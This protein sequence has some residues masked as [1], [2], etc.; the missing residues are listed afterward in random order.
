MQC[1]FL[2]HCP[3]GTH[4]VNS[5]CIVYFNTL[6]RHGLLLLCFSNCFPGCLF[7]YIFQFILSFLFT[8]PEFHFYLS[9]FYTFPAKDFSVYVTQICNL[10]ITLRCKLTLALPDRWA[11]NSLLFWSGL[12][13]DCITTEE[14]QTGKETKLEI[15]IPIKILVS[16]RRH[17]CKRHVEQ[18]TQWDINLSFNK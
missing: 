4:S 11:E 3:Q 8:F 14:S 18:K 2:S 1:R 10:H 7:V 5:S 16:D 9:I 12:Q 17:N 15:N 6:V 13:P